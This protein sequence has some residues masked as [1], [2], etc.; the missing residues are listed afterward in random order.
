LAY[1]LEGLR[2][3]LAAVTPSVAKDLIFTA[4]RVAAAEALEQ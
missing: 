1:P 3:L 2:Q 4:R